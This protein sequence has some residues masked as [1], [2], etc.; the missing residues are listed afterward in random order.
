[1]GIVAP[2]EKKILHQAYCFSVW[3][4]DVESWRPLISRRWWSEN[5]CYRV[6]SNAEHVLMPTGNWKSRHTKGK[7][8]S[9]GGEHVEE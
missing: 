8:F 6:T 9:C 1:M 7:L 5:T 4:T 2:G 3:S